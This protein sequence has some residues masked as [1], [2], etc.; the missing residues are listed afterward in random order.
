[1]HVAFAG[2]EKAGLVIVGIGHRAGFRELAHLLSLTGARCLISRAEH[3]GERMS[4]WLQ[5]RRAG[6]L[7]LEHHLVVEGELRE[8]EPIEV[9]PAILNADASSHVSLDGRR[10]GPTDLFLLN[11]TSGTT[12]MP[13][14]VKH[15]QARWQ[16]FH[17]FA[18]EAGALTDSDVFMSVVSSPFG[19]G[20]WTA[21]V[22]PTLLG[23]PT[24]LCPNFTPE[25]AIELIEQ[26]RVTVL[27]AV[28]TQFIMMLGSR[29]L[30]RADLGSLRVLFTG[31]EA[32]PYERAVGFEEKTGARVLQFYG[33]N[34]VGAV[35]RTTIADSRERRLR[36]AGRVIPEMN[37]RLFDEAGQD[38]TAAGRGQPGC[39]GPTLSG[40]YYGNEQANKQLY[41]DDGWMLLGDLVTIDD[42]GY[43][44]VVGRTDDF[45]IRGGKNISAPGVEEAVATHPD[46]VL[47]AA[48]A[49]PDEVFGERVCVY[50]ELRPGASLSLD[51]LVT[52]LASRGVSKETFPERL[53]VL[54]ELP[55]SSGGKLAK[56]ELRDDIEARLA[57]ERE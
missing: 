13:K 2:I 18:V 51:E 53:I 20:I 1:V 23:V 46:V 6:G 16:A 49:M 57:R 48:V 42:E 28:S 50:A 25:E 12:G 47:A 4:A 44:S 54:A 55:R 3:Q 33:S 11:S 30:E 52:H 38:V 45:I 14:C 8:G 43:L 21:H 7:A 34:E 5:Q 10:L 36:T 24:V 56:R 22:T 39:R 15:D 17:R 29:A 27:A 41:T 26:H 35:S 9:Q 19:F 31:G 32:V 40:G 37:V